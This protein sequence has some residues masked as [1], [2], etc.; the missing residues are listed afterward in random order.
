MYGCGWLCCKH[1]VPIHGYNISHDQVIL[2][3][4]QY[5][6]IYSYTVNAVHTCIHCINIGI[7]TAAIVIATVLVITRSHAVGYLMIVLYAQLQLLGIT[8]E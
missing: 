8:A 6:C 3:T 1:K 7:A 2:M 4:I 5:V